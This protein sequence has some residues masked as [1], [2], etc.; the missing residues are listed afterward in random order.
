[1]VN[2]INYLQVC[3][4]PY[5]QISMDRFERVVE[6]ISQ[7]GTSIFAMRQPGKKSITRDPEYVILSLLSSE[8]LPISTIARRLHRSKPGMS[9]LIGRLIREGKVRRV[10]SK[11]DLRV[12]KIAISEKG[13]DAVNAKRNELKARFETV[14]APLTDEEVA[15]IDS[16]LIELNSIIS[17]LR[18]E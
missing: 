8:N 18:I 5:S 6:N 4:Q 13:L 2:I 15:R 7:L 11:E 12:T 10:P 16:C 3:S 1:M 17:R 14:F 9:A